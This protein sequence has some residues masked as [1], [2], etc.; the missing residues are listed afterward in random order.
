MTEQQQ[1]DPVA[2]LHVV[3]GPVITAAVTAPVV[4]GSPPLPAGTVVPMRAAERARLAV[5]HW[6]GTAT[7][8]AGQLWLHPG[9][10]IHKLVHAAPDRTSAHWV[11]VKSGEWV[12][13]EL[14]GTRAGKVITFSGWAYHLCAIPADKALQGLEFG[15]R[16][17]IRKARWALQRPLRLLGFLVP[18]VIIVLIVI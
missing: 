2:R 12:P 8:G 17:G 9:R 1:K 6:A 4:T 11:Y 3:T 13:R 15:I 18:V 7:E 10:L 16:F 14:H 5:S